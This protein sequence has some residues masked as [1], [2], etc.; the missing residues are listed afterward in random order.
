MITYLPEIYPDELVYSWFCRYYV[1]SGSINHKSALRDIYCKCSDNP[2][3]EFLGHLNTD[4][5]SK[6]RDIQTISELI[7]KHTMF[8]QYARF[9]SLENRKNAIDCLKHDFCDTHR[10]FAVLP[11]TGADRYLKYCPICT[12]ED[13]QKYGETYWHRNHQIRNMQVCYKHNCM[14]E[15]SDVTA[16]SEQTF[17]FCPAETYAI[18]KNAVLCEN[19]NLIKYNKYL[20]DVF[21]API[22][23][24][25]AIPIHIVLFNALDGT[26]YIKNLGKCRNTKLL[27]DD[28]KA[29]YK[30]T[31][32]KD[33]ASFYQVQRVL[34][35]ERFDF[36]AVCQIAFY[37]GVSIED[38]TAPNIKA[39]QIK[40]EQATHYN[41]D[42]PSVHWKRFDNELAPVF[43]QTAN[44]IYI[45]NIDSLRKPMRVSLRRICKEVGIQ[46]YQMAKLP[47][48]KAIFEKYTETAEANMARRIVWAY[49]MLKSEQSDKIYWSDIRSLSGVKRANISK[50]IPY[51]YKAADK[52]I[53]SEIVSIL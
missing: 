5:K 36:S 34:L 9:I 25:N 42:K 26:N 38:L 35:G 13:R 52:N 10:L 3:K 6:I 46:P 37:L 30:D 40:K 39:E 50:V 12:E 21:N 4:I 51:I 41:S 31:D 28:I 29:F 44:D 43:E 15:S 32:I 24:V 33:V 53:A 11:R 27:S 47:K 14:L 49:K 48:C 2:S 45:G 8:P 17:T 18:K 7:L 20:C 19:G 1:H 23:F 16:K 22:D